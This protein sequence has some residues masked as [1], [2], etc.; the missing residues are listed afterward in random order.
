[1]GDFRCLSFD[2]ENDQI[3]LT[4]SWG[5]VVIR[6]SDGVVLQDEKLE[7]GG[8]DQIAILKNSHFVAVSGDGSNPSFTKSTL[9]IYDLNKHS[10]LSRLEHDSIILKIHF[11]PDV[12]IVVQEKKI[13]FYS[14]TC[15]IKT[16]ECPNSAGKGDVV[17]V[18]CSVNTTMV[19]IPSP[20][21][22]SLFLCDYHDPGYVLGE[23][24]GLISELCFVAFDKKGELLALVTEQGRFIHLLAVPSMKSIATYKRGMRK[25]EISCLCFDRSQ[26]Y[27]LL[28]SNRG[29]LHIFTVPPLTTAT[30]SQSQKTKSVFTIYPSKGSDMYCQFESSGL[31]II[32]LSRDLTLKRL[33]VDIEGECVATAAE[34]QVAL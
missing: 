5:F 21:G 7:S 17:A 34:V 30:N 31:G 18:A 32:A 19:T 28:T 6:A 25:A 10:V 4:Y 22:Q 12:L 13:T 11:L 3:A 15:Y 8:C 2:L 23:I 16:F 27:F 26:S 1:M 20:G 24:Q 33:R 14:T 29:T 9:I